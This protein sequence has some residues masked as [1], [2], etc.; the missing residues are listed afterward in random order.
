MND[1]MTETQERKK[2]IRVSSAKAKGRRLQQWIL[3]KIC[4]LFNYVLPDDKDLR[5]ID[6]RPMGQNGTDLIIGA[7]FR[8]KFPFAVE[9]K[10]QEKIQLSDFVKQAYNN[11]SETLP[12][13][14]LVIKNKSMKE[15]LLC[16]NWEGFDFLYRGFIK[17]SNSNN[18]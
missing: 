9:C 2:R 18:I 12:Y 5:Q 14:L 16:L 11:I 7:G 8:D 1:G 13:P 17:S 6:S 4:G 3:Q 15:P 10:N